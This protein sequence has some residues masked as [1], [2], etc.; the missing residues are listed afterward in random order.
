[1]LHY[2]C[3]ALNELGEEAYLANAKIVSPDLRT[4]KLTKEV[5]RAHYANGRTPITLYPEVVPGNPLE[6]PVVARW[7]LN[8]PG[9]LGGDTSYDASDLI[10]YFGDWCLADGMHGHHMQL[11]AIDPNI[12]NNRNNASDQGRKGSCYYANKFLVFGGKVDDGIKRNAVSLGLDTPRSHEELADILRKS[13]VMYCYEPSSLVYEALACGCP[14]LIVPSDYWAKNGAPDVL[15]A[16]G[17]ALSSDAN[18]LQKAKASL[19]GYDHEKQM[20]ESSQAAWW[21]VENFV[22]VTRKVVAQYN[23]QQCLDIQNPSYATLRDLWSVVP[24]QRKYYVELVDTRL[25]ALPVLVSPAT[26]SA[27]GDEGNTQSKSIG[28]VELHLFDQRAAQW[29]SP[30]V[31]HILITQDEADDGTGLSRTLQSLQS[32]HYGNVIATV[33]SRHSAPP[34]LG[35]GRLEWL[36]SSDDHRLV[37]NEAIAKSPAGWCG[38]IRAGDQFAQEAFLRIAEFINDHP[39]CNALYTDE[40]VLDTDGRLVRHLLK[41]DFDEDLLISAGY[42]GGLLLAKKETWINAGGWRALPR[43]LDEF[44]AA[45]RLAATS[46][47]GLGHVEGVLYYRHH[48]DPALLAN[49]Q[50][51]EEQRLTLAKELLGIIIPDASV[52]PGLAPGLL[53]VR[54]PLTHAPGIT[55]VI[56]TRDNVE[57]LDKLISSIF[58]QTAYADYELLIVDNDSRDEKAKAYLDGLREI[59]PSKIR[60]IQYDKPFNLAA[61]LNH[62][63]VHAA[64]ELLLFLHDD[65]SVIHQDWLS[66]MV[67]QLQ[68]PGIKAVGARLLSSDGTTIVEAGIVPSQAGILER[69]FQGWP[70]DHPAPLGRVHAV[71]RVSAVSA[72]CLLVAKQDFDAL[73]GMDAENFPEKFADIDFC[74]KLTQVGHKIMWT[75]YATL[76]HD[77]DNTTWGDKDDNNALLA[78]WGKAMVVDPCHNPYIALGSN[79]SQLEQEPN[80]IPDPITWHPLPTIYSMPS[81]VDGAGNYRVIQPV[82]CSTENGLIRGRVGS[83]YPVPMLIEKLD[84]DVVYSQRQLEDRQLENLERYKKLLRC[85]LIL[86]F[87]DLLTNVPDKN[88][89]KKTLLKDMKRR[90]RQ[91]GNLAHRFTVST[92]SLAHEFREFHEDIRVVPN[93]LLPSHWTHLTS[94]RN[95]SGKPRVGWA[96][97]VSHQGDLELIRDV[98]KATANEVD[99]VFMGMCPQ[100]LKPYIKE[101]HSGAPFDAYPKTLAGLS[102]DLAIAPLEINPF[103]ECKSHLRLLEYGILGIPVIATDITPYQSGFPVTLVRNRHQEWVRAIRDHVNDLVEMRKRGDILR[104]YILDHWMLDQHLHE[105]L[106]AWTVL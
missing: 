61:L 11:P 2:L 65:V 22:S 77:T 94:Q 24:K 69:P 76:I 39:A 92:E 57:R 54:Y 82:L 91:A 60:V 34:N 48:A 17:V 70:I 99:W 58:A 52:E 44:D 85:K 35:Q 50:S 15:D 25:D 46:G 93:A 47:S 45:I 28:P 7:L 104:Q 71:Q 30:P 10:F 78:K 49:D 98:V 4:P 105:W 51:T 14:V 18:A 101:F 64:K 21:Q 97:G 88:I 103:N 40:A 87:D 100:E 81:D 79:S 16:P 86:D 106:A 74:L 43:G 3:H 83:G 84:I 26:V 1:M 59:D 29:L 31:F 63:A 73:G 42:V 36:C 6:S 13:E 68:R 72:A 56:P 95:T 67:V 5:M 66:N 8:K 32:Q 37:A 55:V 96:G 80:F 89:H 38:L 19:A 41:P 62:G 90:L 33:I 53:H 75:P 9:H 102:F 23:H 12:F 27:A 20:Y